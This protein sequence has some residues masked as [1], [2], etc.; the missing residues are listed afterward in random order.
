[1]E[2]LAIKGGKPV[3]K[4]PFPAR[5]LFD[6]KEKEAALRVIE[7]TM[8]GPDAVD[9]AAM[10]PEV[11]AYKKEFAKFFGVKFAQPVTSGT[12]A[13][14]TALGC[15]RLEPGTEIITSPITDPGT[16][17]PI[18]MLN[19]IPVFAD[20]DYETLNITADSIEE[21]ITKKTK[22]IIPVHLAG[23]SCAMDP[24]MKLAKKYKLIVIEDSA[25]SHGTKYKGRYV[26]SIGHLGAFSLM[27]GKHMTSAGQGGMVIT[28]NEKLYWNAK[29][30]ADRG[31]PFNSKNLTNLFLGAQYR[32]TELQ[33]AI[34]RAQLKKLKGRIK[35]RQSILKKL[36]KGIKNLKAVR[37][38]KTIENTEPNPWFCFI[39]Y[40]KIKMKV[41]KEKFARAVAAEGIPV[42]AHYT[43][44]MY[45]QTWIKE[46]NT[47]GNS[48]YPWSSYRNI[49]YKNSCP[50][51]EKALVDHMTLYINECWT[52]KEVR[53]TVKAL[54]KVEKYYLK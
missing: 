7:K 35:K 11:E 32:V 2:K 8:K 34:G 14:H 30:F 27:A 25:Q 6:E 4:N 42:G 45:E 40:D 33:A 53:D 43:T 18:L 22:V 38:W 48:H 50:V 20:V 31:K 36:N 54:E 15:L 1:M 17:A 47:Y 49:N 29:R 16:V 46:K 13:V 44:V 26:G 23:Q 9:M 51:A 5:I 19:C 52:D 37:L 21:K 39:H 28:N 12:A 41:N 10:G 24:I 3:R